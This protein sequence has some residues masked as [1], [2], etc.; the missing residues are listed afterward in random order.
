MKKLIILPIVFMVMLSAFTA[1][2]L[3]EVDEVT[4]PNRPSSE[5]VLNNA[6][7][8]DLQFLATGLESASRFYNNARAD[9]TTLVG[10]FGREIYYFNSSDPNFITAWLQLPGAVRAE[11]NPNFFVDASAYEVPYTA[12]RQAD[13]LIEAANNT[14]SVNEQERNGL[15]GFAK[16]FKAFQL[17]VPLNTQYQNG[18]IVELNVTNPLEIGPFL[19]YEEA[20]AAIRA[21]LDEG[22]QNLS[23][24]NFNALELTDG[25]DGFNTAETMLQVN[26]AIAARAALYAEDWQGVLDA[27]DDSFI[28]LS[29]GASVLNMGPEFT[30]AG[31]SDFINPYF[32]PPDASSAN[33]I[34]VHPS[35]LEDAED[36]DLRVENKFSE[37]TTPATDPELSGVEA[38]FQDGRFTS[39]TEPYPIIRNEELILMRAEALAQRNQGTDLIDAVD[40]IN[41]VRNTWDLPDFLSASQSE[42]ID[43]V[44]F[45]RR[46]SLWMEGH[47]WIDAR[48]YDRLDEI[49]TGLDGGRVP[50]QIAR[51]QAELDF[52]DF[53]N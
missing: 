4:D 19:S 53:D 8:G 14:E 23:N 48:R 3:V 22:A 18:I 44:L 9:W 50:T 12:V 27:L 45:E 5:A 15:L 13:L 34:V 47:R 33:L 7:R 35:M 6:S 1:C 26:R 21:I 29:E 38:N 20:L 17:L 43:Q 40:A 11:E 41:I 25:F 10:D 30:F 46:Y 32:F 37:R 49:P 51:P 28:E 16:T 31:G 24:G 52:A 36:G 39:S 42:I 2:E